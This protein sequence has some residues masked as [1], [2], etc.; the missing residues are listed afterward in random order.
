MYTKH[1]GWV[2]TWLFLHP[3]ASFL[4]SGDQAMQST[5]C[6]CP[7]RQQDTVQWSQKQQQQQH[8]HPDATQ[9]WHYTSGCV[10]RRLGRQVPETHGSIAWTAGQISKTK[11]MKCYFLTLFSKYED[12]KKNQCIKA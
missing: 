1:V 11:Q 3:E 12:K 7:G 4:P 2:H 6:V 10:V 5:Q 8:K 9:K